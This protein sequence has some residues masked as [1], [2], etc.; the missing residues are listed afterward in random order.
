M[1][2]LSAFIPHDPFYLLTV[3]LLVV[4]VLVATVFT[5]T[6][7]PKSKRQAPSTVEA[8]LKFIYTC[9]LKPHTGDGSGSQQ[10]ALVSSQIL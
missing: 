5:Y 4:G 7:R 1:L 3:T 9:F 8:Y 6:L 2:G 10:D